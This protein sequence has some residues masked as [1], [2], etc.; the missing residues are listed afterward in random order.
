MKTVLFAELQE[1]DIT[2]LAW[3]AGLAQGSGIVPAAEALNGILMRIQ[4][5]E[6]PEVTEVDPEFNPGMVMGDGDEV[7]REATE[8]ELAELERVPDPQ[9]MPPPPMPPTTPQTDFGAGPPPGP[10]R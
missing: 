10:P 7:P 4:R 3:A 1:S 5:M 8:A 9:F 2:W 6:V